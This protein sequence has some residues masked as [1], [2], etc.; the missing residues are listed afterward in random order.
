MPSWITV[1]L[2]VIVSFAASLLLCERVLA[3]RAKRDSEA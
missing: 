3:W 1:A 2:I